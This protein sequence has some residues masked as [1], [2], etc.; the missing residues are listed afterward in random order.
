MGMEQMTRE[1]AKETIRD[2][3]L[4]WD[5][6][7]EAVMAQGHSKADAEE[8]VGRYF[9]AMAKKENLSN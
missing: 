5:T 4:K 3:L 8:I 7:M 6:G 1:E 9:T 2:M